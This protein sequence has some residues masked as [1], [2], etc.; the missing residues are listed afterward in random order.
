M[1]GHSTHM[2]RSC[3]ATP[4]LFVA[5]AAMFDINVWQGLGAINIEEDMNRISKIAGCSTYVEAEL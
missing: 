1:K 3:G 5:G 2:S 4:S